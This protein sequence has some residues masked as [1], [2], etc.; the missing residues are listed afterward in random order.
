MNHINISQIL[1]AIMLLEKGTNADER[2]NQERLYRII[3]NN[4][5]TDERDKKA[6]MKKVYGVFIREY[7]LQMERQGFYFFK[8]GSRYVIE[9]DDDDNTKEIGRENFFLTMC[10]GVCANPLLGVMLKRF[11][12]YEDGL[13]NYW[14]NCVTQ[15]PSSLFAAIVISIQHAYSM[16]FLFAD[17]STSIKIFSRRQMITQNDIQKNRELIQRAKKDILSTGC[18]LKPKAMELGKHFTVSAEIEFEKGNE[19][20]DVEFLLEDVAQFD[21]ILPSDEYDTD[22]WKDKMLYRF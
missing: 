11:I 17:K 9:F 18:V 14:D 16:E 1:L 22:S 12:D 5:N 3:F 2:L 7:S 8:R 15:Y 10:G 6:T 20:Y 19:K 13:Y 4:P 21:I